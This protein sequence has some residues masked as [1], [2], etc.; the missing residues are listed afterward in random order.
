MFHFF[1]LLLFHK[2]LLLQLSQDCVADACTELDCRQAVVEI[3]LAW[4]CASNEQNV[5]HRGHGVL[6]STN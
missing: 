5:R 2:G 1:E 6:Q 4:A 3:H